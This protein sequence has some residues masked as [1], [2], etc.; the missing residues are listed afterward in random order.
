MIILAVVLILVLAGLGVFM[1]LRSSSSTVDESTPAMTSAAGLR[2]LNAS[3]SLEPDGDLLISGMVENTTDK[4]RNA[5][6]IVVDVFDANGA[7][8][9]KIRLLNG[10][11]LFTRNDYEILAKRGVNIQE[12][13]AKALQEQGVVVPP[14]G[15][16]AFEMRYLQP[17]IGIAS[18]NASL[19]PFDPV[20]LYKE[21]AEEAK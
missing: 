7:V 20:R 18:F 13:K 2:I 21:I 14:K 1:Y 8:M 19:H 9:N 17:P 6:Y 10:K 4:E 5:W 11:Q 12:L 15:K 16:V 3:G